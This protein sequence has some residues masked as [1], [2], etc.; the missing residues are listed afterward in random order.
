MDLPGGAKRE[1]DRMLEELLWSDP[2]SEP[3]WV[4]SSRGAGVQ[5][6]P[7]VTHAFL[8]RNQ[9]ELLIRS[10]ELTPEGYY[11]AHNGKLITVFSASH[12]CGT[13]RNKGRRSVGCG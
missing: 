1:E 9:L 2:R 13:N 10:H 12:Y 8:Q 3:G 11:V 4:R 7:D 5:F 6:G